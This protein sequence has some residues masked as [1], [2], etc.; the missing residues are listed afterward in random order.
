MGADA[1]TYAA[2]LEH[3]ISAASR[4]Y[5]RKLLSD[6]LQRVR[7]A[8]PRTAPPAPPPSVPTPL[9]SEPGKPQAPTFS[10]VK[11][12]MFDQ[13]AKFVKIYISSLPGIADLPEEG[14]VARFEERSLQLDLVGLSAA[15][16]NR[17]LSVPTLC[18]AVVPEQCS[19]VRKPPDTLL[20]KLRKA[21]EGDEWGSLDD[22]AAKKK[23]KQEEKVKAN[24]GKST[25][26]LLSEMYADADEEGKES[27]AKAFEEGRAKREARRAGA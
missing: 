27:L 19:C 14:V 21:T 10:M 2:D 23:A 9:R 4:D 15:P 11:S 8:A 18:A 26:Q 24:E 20:V 6:E 5:T 1:D 12:Y 3:L 13:S 22:S 25:A 17:R 16:P 7:A